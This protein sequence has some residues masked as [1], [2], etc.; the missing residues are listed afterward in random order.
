MLIWITPTEY[1]LNSPE[2]IERLVQ[3]GADKEVK[4]GFVRHTPLSVAVQFGNEACVSYLLKSGANVEGPTRGGFTPL[5]FAAFY[6][7]LS[8]V[9][10]L[11]DNG[12]NPLAKTPSLL[13]LGTT[14]RKTHPLEN[15]PI[16]QHDQIVRL[17]KDA[18]K[19]WKKSG[20]R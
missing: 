15:V 12:A 9:K 5:H 3:A 14:P 8:I 20:K 10:M 7:R 1:A 11:L 19:D 4:A 2:T 6:G 18:E 17:L 13:K 16:A